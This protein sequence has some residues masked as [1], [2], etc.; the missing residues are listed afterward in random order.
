VK[1]ACGFRDESQKYEELNIVVLG[2][3]YDS[4]ESLK[5]FREK[6]RIPFNFLSDSEK[7]VGKKYGV[8]KFLFPSRKTFLIDED[9]ILIRIFQDVN[10]NTHPEDVV[11]A[12][13]EVLIGE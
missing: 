3:S 8:N 7:V 11:K 9:G 2:I 6:Y 12:F 5:S 4:K 10:L 13:N 1:Q